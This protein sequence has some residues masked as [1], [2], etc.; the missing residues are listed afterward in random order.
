MPL[1]LSPPERSRVTEHGRSGG[2]VHPAMVRA[3]ARASAVSVIPGMRTTGRK[4]GLQI[5]EPILPQ[6]K[7]PTR[8][9]ASEPRSGGP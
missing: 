6:P 9:R 4:R 8:Y 1:Y 5:G 7:A 2:G 3:Q